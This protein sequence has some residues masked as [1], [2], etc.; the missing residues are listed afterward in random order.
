MP[1][2]LVEAAIAFASLIDE[3]CIYVLQSSGVLAHPVRRRVVSILV[4]HNVLRREDIAASVAAD[5]SVPQDDL[6]QIEAALHHIHLPKLDEELLI[7]YDQRNG[8]VALW[9]DR[10]TA[11]EML[12]SA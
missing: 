9:K 12:D 11:T 1:L 4:T 2:T 3:I 8:D 10:D 7:E 5:E 6:E